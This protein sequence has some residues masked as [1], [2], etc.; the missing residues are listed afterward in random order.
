MSSWFNDLRLRWKILVAPA[1][2]ILILVGLGSYALRTLSANQL[3]VDALMA[4]PVRQSE[5]VEE[6]TSPQRQPTRPMRRRS[7]PWPRT[8]PRP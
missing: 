6:F 4:G 1:L 2:L 8:A 5:V 7:P 3:A